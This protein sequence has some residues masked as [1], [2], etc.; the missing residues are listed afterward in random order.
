[1]LSITTLNFELRYL[2]EEFYEN[3]VSNLTET[4]TKDTRPYCVLLVKVKKLT[5]ALPLRSNLPDEDGI[6]MKTIEN[7]VTGK[8][9]G[10]DFSK[11]ILITSDECLKK[12]V[13]Q[14]KEKSEL[15]FI[16]AQDKK[17]TREFKKYVEGYITAKKTNLI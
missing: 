7:T 10:I 12:D 9:K 6:G 2:S 16:Q 4:L 13:V 11:A 15:L 5:F 14:L 8:F 17:I 1:M 3:V